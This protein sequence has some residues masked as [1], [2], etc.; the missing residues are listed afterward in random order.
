MGAVHFKWAPIMDTEAQILE[1]APAIKRRR[2][3]TP[4]FKAKILAECREP[5]A[6]L[7]GVAIRNDLNPNLVQKWRRASSATGQNDFVQLPAPLSGPEV[8]APATVRID[9]PTPKGTLVVHWPMSE[10]HQSVFWLRAL[11]R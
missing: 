3:H 6:T 7:A 5:G 11:T 1:A 10:V 8:E 2:R 4:A 9:V